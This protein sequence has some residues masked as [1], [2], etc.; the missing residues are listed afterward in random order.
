MANLQSKLYNIESTEQSRCWVFPSVTNNPVTKK[1]HLTDAMGTEDISL[2]E[3]MRQ[4]QSQIKANVETINDNIK[5]E[6]REG[7]NEMKAEIIGLNKKIEG[8][9]EETE[10]IK[11]VVNTNIVTNKSRFQ[12]M[13]TRLDEIVNESQK[14][15]KQKRKRDTLEGKIVEKSAAAVAFQPTGTSYAKVV[16]QN[17][18]ATVEDLQFKS[19]WARQMSQ[20]SLEKQLEQVSIDAARMENEGLEKMRSRTRTKKV[21]MGNS[22]EFH[23]NN[24]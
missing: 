19:S 10:K 23:N 4:I 3:F 2:V 9:A 6:I 11:N 12:K 1:E 8:V 22:Q 14:Q 13:E 18:T 5:R 16:K 20:Q 7:T 24:D 15:V 17:E 21:L